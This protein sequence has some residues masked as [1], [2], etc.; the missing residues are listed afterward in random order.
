MGHADFRTR[1][2][3][4]HGHVSPAKYEA[5]SHIRSIVLTQRPTLRR[6][7][8]ATVAE[9]RPGATREQRATTVARCASGSELKHYQRSVSAVQVSRR[10]A[11]LLGRLLP[12]TG[13]VKRA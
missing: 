3:H 2:I 6:R 9:R 1:S 8:A 4:G 7:R 5:L 12:P 11:R 10:L 13:S